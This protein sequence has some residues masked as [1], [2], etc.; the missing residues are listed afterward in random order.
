MCNINVATM[1][2]MLTSIII[3]VVNGKLDNSITMLSS[4]HTQVLSFFYL[5]CKLNTR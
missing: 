4:W 3:M 1:F 5:L 2:L